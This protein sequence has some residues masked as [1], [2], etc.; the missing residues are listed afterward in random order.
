MKPVI[1][2]AALLLPLLMACAGE[3]PEVD[4]PAHEDALKDA[5]EDLTSS[6]RSLTESEPDE[7]IHP[8]EILAAYREDNLQ[9]RLKYPD[10]VRVGLSLPRRSADEYDCTSTQDGGGACSMYLEENY[11]PKA[12]RIASGYRMSL[13][14]D[15]LEETILFRDAFNQGPVAVACNWDEY[16]KSFRKLAF[17]DCEMLSVG[18]LPQKEEPPA[19]GLTEP[20]LVAPPLSQPTPVPLPT[21]TR[22]PRPT[23]TLFPTPTPPTPPE[24]NDPPLVQDGFRCFSYSIWNQYRLELYAQETWRSDLLMDGECAAITLRDY[25]TVDGGVYRMTVPTGHPNGDMILDAA[26]SLEGDSV[27]EL[28]DRARRREDL[29]LHCEGSADTERG[30]LSLV[31]CRELE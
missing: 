16:W 19:S 5:A 25:W 29:S 20:L 28:F 14:F 22:T 13:E 1:I 2:L 23:A 10:G 9:A 18:S 26:L 4:I 11:D 8:S 6:V 24:D 7:F 30:Y 12:V 17:E 21:P 15:G 3:L 27:E 31:N